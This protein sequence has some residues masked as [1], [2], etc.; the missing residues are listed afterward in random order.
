MIS[1]T[2]MKCIDWD[3]MKLFFRSK[4]GYERYK[5]VKLVHRQW[6]VMKRN[7]EWGDSSSPQCVLCNKAPETC[8]HVLQCTS[9]STKKLI[10]SELKELHAYMVELQTRPLLRKHIMRI[11][12]QWFASFP[13]P[14][15]NMDHMQDVELDVAEAI[16]DQISIGVDNFVRG[17]F[18]WK[19]GTVQNKFYVTIVKKLNGDGKM[20]TRKMMDFL[21][22]MTHKIWKQRCELVNTTLNQSYEARFRNECTTLYI[23]L[24][25]KKRDFPVM[26]RY[27]LERDK[28]YF[29]QAKLSAIK[30]WMRRVQLAVKEL[31][32][33]TQ[34]EDIRKWTIVKNKKKQVNE[35]NTVEE[36]SP[37]HTVNDENW[38][39]TYGGEDPDFNTTNIA[40]RN[41]FFLTIQRLST[42][43]IYTMANL[44]TKFFQLIPNGES[45]G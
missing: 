2:T 33:K 38:V 24:Q 35:L 28:H 17:L 25:S 11:L 5:L 26:F 30:S 16:N 21:L 37:I 43:T 44:I 14:K 12:R 32:R 45:V 3:N 23:S 41:D 4:K 10:S 18:S 34:C 22:N 19:I 20:W 13:V 15:L 39:S 8:N 7:F 40:S 29:Q 36:N 1:D 6:P 27:L 31:E 42:Y 9:E